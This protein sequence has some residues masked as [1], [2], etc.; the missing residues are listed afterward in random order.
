VPLNIEVKGNPASLRTTSAWLTSVGDQVQEAA[1]EV[2]RAR[3]DSQGEWEGAASEGFRGVMAKT[4]A[5]V[6]DVAADVDSTAKALNMFADELDGCKAQMNRAREIA[7][8]A[9]LHTTE[10][11]ISEPGAPPSPPAG[12]PQPN[13]FAPGAQTFAPRPKGP[14]SNEFYRQFDAYEKACNAYLAKAKAYLEAAQIVASCRE[15]EG[16]A[17][18]IL[19]KFLKDSADKAPFLISDFAVGLVGAVGSRLSAFR[20]ASASF[21]DAAVKFAQHLARLR[22]AGLLTKSLEERAIL[23]MTESRRYAEETK[24]SG[25]KAQLSQVYESRFGRLLLSEHAPA[26]RALG[27]IPIAGWSITG[28][29]IG[30]DVYRG[31]NP[32]QATASGMGG[33][34]AATGAT[35][36]LLAMG[37]PAGWAVAGGVIVG[38]GVGFAIDEWGDDI[39][40]GFQDTWHNIGE[41]FKHFGE[42]PRP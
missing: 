7:E 32:V 34:F 42:P 18:N 17:Q 23:G 13:Q 10:T 35:A 8:K 12:T 16:Q 41:G 37:T 36:G 9:G 1:A 2:L 40:H 29:S 20:Q 33:T 3:A 30:V 6:E 14:Y 28:I 27:G 39:A 22:S 19:L 11:T 21:S 4:G 24:L 15:R 26:A 25:F 5:G 31:K 38:A